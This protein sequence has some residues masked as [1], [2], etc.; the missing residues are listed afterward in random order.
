MLV[1][2]KA[3]EGDR[4]LTRG[5]VTHLPVP[6]DMDDWHWAM[7]L[8]QAR[9]V[10]VGVEHFRSLSPLCAGSVM[11]QLNDCWPVTS[12]AAVDG[13]GRRKPL[14]YALRHAHADRLVTVQP[15]DGGLVAVLVNDTAQPGRSRCR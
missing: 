9:A 15:R 13:D 8:N 14:F 7:S 11:W 5:L 3:M 4:K 6:D 2:Q 12:W 10:Q 1:H